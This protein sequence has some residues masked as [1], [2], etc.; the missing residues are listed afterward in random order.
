VSSVFPGRVAAAAQQLLVCRFRSRLNRKLLQH[1]AAHLCK[2][3]H[4]HAIH[5]RKHALPQMTLLRKLHKAMCDC[6]RCLLESIYADATW[7]RAVLT[8]PLHDPAG[9]TPSAGNS[10]L[11]NLDRWL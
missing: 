5:C 9:K 2:A 4:S 10:T 7:T 8:N 3:A 1:W 11:L 6:L